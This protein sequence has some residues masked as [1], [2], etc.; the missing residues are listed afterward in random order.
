MNL[1][2]VN[3]NNEYLE[4]NNNMDYDVSYFYNL[5]SENKICFDCGGAFPSCVSIN[6]GVFLCKFCG[7]NHRKKLNNNI[8]FIHD[9]NSNWDQYLLAYAIR[10]GNSRF[11]RLCLQ[12]EVPCQS[13]TQNDDEKIN[14]YI[15]RLG[16][17]NRLVLR[18]EINCDEPPKPLYHEVAKDPINLNVIYFPE[19]ENYQLFKGNISTNVN[20]SNNNQINSNDNASM[21]SKIW[22]GTKTTFNVMKNTTGFIYNTGK[23]IVSFLGNAAFTGIKYVGSSVWN[24]YMNNN[25]NEIKN[26]DK[27]NNSLNYNNFQSNQLNEGNNNIAIQLQNKNVNN[28]YNNNY[29]SNKNYNYNTNTN[30]NMNM[31]KL[32]NLQNK[33]S[34]TNSNRYNIYTIN[35]NGAKNNMNNIITKPMKSKSPNLNQNNNNNIPNYYD[36]NSINNESVN[37]ITFYLNNNNSIDNISRL[38]SEL[39]KKNSLLNHDNIIVNTKY[40]NDKNFLIYNDKKDK[41]L[42]LDKNNMNSKE[43]ISMISKPGFSNQLNNSRIN[44]AYPNYNSVFGNEENN[45]S[46]NDI[47]INREINDKNVPNIIGEEINQEKARYPIYESTNILD[48]N[49]FAPSLA[50]ETNDI[51]KREN[52]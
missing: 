10:G 12:Y 8:S 49:S 35:D 30:S 41:D 20:N 6:N 40:I 15:I 21:G 37:N 29:E 39:K 50:P 13:L 17:Y 46:N 9:I 14:K 52:D 22:E 28:Q 5:D 33:N 31:N 19:F 48:N 43:N 44:N 23:P 24:Y 18:S 2:T 47:L 36:I 26:N 42:N 4:N 38:N 1:E 27:N 45:I 7:D 16:E 34:L 51:Y 11:K 25:D 32:V 3:E